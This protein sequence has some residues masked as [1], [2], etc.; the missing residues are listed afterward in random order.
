MIQ[1]TQSTWTAGGPDASLLS[2]SGAFVF[3]L[4]LAVFA[5]LGA[6]YFMRGKRLGL[7]KRGAQS[8]QGRLLVLETVPLGQKRH[9]TVVE[10]GGERHLLGL[11][12]G[13]VNYLTKISSPPETISARKESRDTRAFRPSPASG[14]I[15]KL[16]KPNHSPLQGSSFESQYEQ[17]K[18]KLNG[19]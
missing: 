12:P 1:S 4:C 18:A 7:R 19:K 17:L 15:H 2:V 13:Q 14:L 8:R 5:A 9:L 16:V 6:S 3:V 10:V 11:G